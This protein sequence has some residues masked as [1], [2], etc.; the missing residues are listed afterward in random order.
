MLEHFDDA[1]AFR[2]HAEEYIEAV[3]ILCGGAERPQVTVAFLMAPISNNLGIAAELTFKTLLLE[4]GKSIADVKRY[5]HNLTSLYSALFF[6]LDQQKFETDV[7][8]H[9]KQFF[10][11]PDQTNNK[12]TAKGISPEIYFKFPN[13]LATLNSNYYLDN[14]SDHRFRTRYPNT[15][16][17]KKIVETGIVHY[18]LVKLMGSLERYSN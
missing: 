8:Q 13:Q 6:F 14:D 18:G 17:K 1:S 4:H 12:L 3:E 11:I 15:S 5:G 7:E 16:K 2:R 10:S 9:A